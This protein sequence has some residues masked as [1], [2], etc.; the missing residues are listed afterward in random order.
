MA[1]KAELL[2]KA[3]TLNLDVN[4]NNTIA[5]IEEAITKAETVNSVEPDTEEPNSTE[6]LAKSGKRSAKGIKAAEEKQDKIDK[7]HASS[8]DEEDEDHPVKKKNPAPITRSR[9][10]RRA[11]GYRAK[12][13]LIDKSKEYSIKEASDIIGKTSTTKFDSSIEL[14]INLN[15]DPRQADQNVRGTV[16]LP[17]GTGK[18]QRIA[19]FATADKHDEAIKA[20]AD[21]VGEDEFL[22][23]LDKGQIDFDI[24]I[25]MP[26]VMAKLGKYARL[27]GPKGLMPNPKSGT[28]TTDIAKAVKEAKG[29]RVE[30]RVDKQ[31]IVHVGI[32]KVSFKPEQ[33]ANNANTLLKSL[34]DARPA[35]VKGV[36]IQ[37]V[38]I[39]TTM[40]PSITIKL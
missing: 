16:S 36:Y 5:E 24:L 29:G 34:Q 35:S 25:A 27:L 22:H 2:E 19:V 9:L 6:I 14:H 18:T 26:Q 20:G 10:A 15:V 30:Y 4:A 37:K 1:K 13:E 8:D 33:V 38:S 39:T 28:V 21:I 7:Q 32:G 12:S 11:K 31:S 40:G 23:L 3:Q 17:H